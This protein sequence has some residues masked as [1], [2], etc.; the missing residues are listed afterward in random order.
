M[1]RGTCWVVPGLVLGVLVSLAACGPGDPGT[2]PRRM[3]EW[4]WLEETHAELEEL[5]AERAELRAETVEVAREL[6]RERR[7]ES[8]ERLDELETQIADLEDRIDEISAEF[9]QRLV[10]FINEDP[11]RGGR[12]PTELQL[13]AVRMKSDE[14]IAI[15]R[16]Y[17]EK[18]GDYRR[19][20]SIYETAMAIDP[21]Y[22]RLQEELDRAQEMRYVTEERFSQ[23]ERG[24]SKYEVREILGQVN[25]LNR[26][27]YP[28][29]RD[30]VAWFYSKG[31]R[32]PAGIWLEKNPETGLYEVYRADFDVEPQ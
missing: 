10:R 13:A 14:D 31:N 25:L 20:I 4:E 9:G 8:R 32:N 6:R 22:E 7:P 17:I 11:I 27:E 5:R 23:I 1:M 24:M 21:D 28:G 16:E 29:D 19:A 2:D 3:A 26:Q 12:E 18:G 15:A 30:V